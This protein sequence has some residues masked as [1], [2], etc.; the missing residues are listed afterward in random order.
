MKLLT[1]DQDMLLGS[2]RTIYQKTVFVLADK[3]IK[4]K[5]LAHPVDFGQ[6]KILP[7][8][9]EYRPLCVGPEIVVNDK[10]SRLQH[11]TSPMHFSFGRNGHD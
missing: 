11:L 6:I 3:P 10:I 8:T 1:V 2:C 9:R 5:L 4:R 7:R